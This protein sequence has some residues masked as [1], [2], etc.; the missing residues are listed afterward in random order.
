MEIYRNSIY[1]NIYDTILDKYSGNAEIVSNYGYIKS[2][3]ILYR[4]F[5]CKPELSLLLLFGN[6]FTLITIVEKENE[7]Y[8]Q[9]YRQKRTLLR[10]LRF[11]KKFLV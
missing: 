1:Q 10:W 8:F 3:L 6:Y 2:F 4:V 9:T 5:K 7:F 11:N